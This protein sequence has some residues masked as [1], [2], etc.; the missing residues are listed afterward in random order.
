MQYIERPSDTTSSRI[1]VHV[2]GDVLPGVIAVPENPSGTVVFAH[3]SGTDNSNPRDRA[4]A[5]VLN[6]YGLATLLIDLLT[7]NEHKFEYLARRPHFDVET[8]GERLVEAIDWINSQ[9]DLGRL[10]IGLLGASTGAAVA[11]RAAAARPRQV[12]AVVCRGGR[13]ELAG[14]VLT[15]VQAPTLLIV[16]AKDELVVHVNRKSADKLH[17]E[18]CVQVVP[19]ATHL[20]D[21]AGTL[22]EV[23]RLAREW[24][25]KHLGVRLH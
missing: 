7:A 22:D 23:G 14:D 24:F 15:Q 3:D 5:N 16:G 10:P 9:E 1:K 11:M 13:P 17:C 25:L 21:E 18:H 8:Q 6:H 20:F 12:S 19:G 4:L 2:N